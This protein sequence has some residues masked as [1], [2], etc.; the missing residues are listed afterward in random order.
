MP[1]G[2]P[3]GLSALSFSKKSLVSTHCLQPC[4]EQSTQPTQSQEFSFQ[5]IQD[6]LLTKLALHE[7]FFPFRDQLELFENQKHVILPKQH[8]G[9]LVSRIQNLYKIDISIK[10]DIMG[11][12][13]FWILQENMLRKIDAQYLRLEKQIKLKSGPME[14]V[15]GYECEQY[16]VWLLIDDKYLHMNDKFVGMLPFELKHG[17]K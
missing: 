1:L 12:R 16:C 4:G 11:A 5:N 3:F 17:A 14:K 13:H 8:K 6:V 9:L 7:L 15:V 10:S 2:N